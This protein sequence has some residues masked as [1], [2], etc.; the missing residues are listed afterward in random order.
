MGEKDKKKGGNGN[1]SECVGK[2]VKHNLTIILGIG[3]Y[4]SE[5]ECA[6]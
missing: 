4:S 1:N 6:S 5:S 2:R 3:D